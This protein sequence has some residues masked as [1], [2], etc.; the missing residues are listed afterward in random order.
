M[1]FLN[2]SSELNVENSKILSKIKAL[3]SGDVWRVSQM[4]KNLDSQLAT[5]FAMETKCRADF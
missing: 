2:L 3:S 5:K 4:Q 1:T